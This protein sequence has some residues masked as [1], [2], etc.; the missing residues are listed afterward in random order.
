[1]KTAA[2]SGHPYYPQVSVL[3]SVVTPPL[4]TWPTTTPGEIRADIK[5]LEKE[6]EGLL[7][8]LLE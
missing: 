3:V 8:E 4:P 2:V 1:V 6:T 7:K 5:A